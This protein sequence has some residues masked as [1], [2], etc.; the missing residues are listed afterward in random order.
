[1]KLSAAQWI[2]L[3]TALILV[4]S[5]L[6]EYR[7]GNA[8]NTTGFFVFIGALFVSFAG[9]MLLLANLSRRFGFTPSFYSAISHA[10]WWN[11]LAVLHFLMNFFFIL[12][13]IVFL[14]FSL[15]FWARAIRLIM[16]R[17]A[18]ENPV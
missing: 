12:S 11:F 7:T 18:R 10:L 15:L 6:G 9:S 8:V 17:C 16:Q 5:F 13:G 4:A 2:T 1:M 3:A 14:G